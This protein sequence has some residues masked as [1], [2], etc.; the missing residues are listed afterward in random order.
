MR[1]AALALALALT[2][3]CAARPA[4]DRPMPS[5]RPV[6][7]AAPSWWYAKPGVASVP[8]GDFRRLAAAAE[9]AA[10][11]LLFTVDRVD[12]REG[13][14]TTEP[15]VSGQW[16][17]PWRREQQT[18][19]DVADS[20]LATVRRT[21]RFEFARDGD[22]D[23]G[24]DGGGDDASWTVTPKVLVERESVAERRITAASDYRSFFGGG[25]GVGGTR[26]SD[27]GVLL[28]SRYFYPVGRDD[29]M[30]RKLASMIE[31]RVRRAESRDAKSV[32]ASR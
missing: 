10:R 24:V 11:D 9:S 30:E 14:V 23:G 6:A 7:Q 28:P 12:Y 8:S 21:I 29:A 16:F 18:A 2:A 27:R 17:E 22:A 3:G 26:E 32:A 15:M 31:R 25:A 19:L 13:V 4:D 5:G 1:R 20:S